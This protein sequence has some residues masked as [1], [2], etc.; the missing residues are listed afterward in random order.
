MCLT[1]WP[2]PYKSSAV[3]HGKKSTQTVVFGLI[4]LPDL[5]HLP[6]E[7]LPG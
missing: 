5:H 7:G 2:Y 3:L 4:S 6:P 1:P